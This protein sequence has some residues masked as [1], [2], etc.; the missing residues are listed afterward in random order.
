V[1]KALQIAVANVTIGSIQENTTIDVE[2]IATVSSEQAESVA[3]SVTD[4]TINS[5]LASAGMTVGVIAVV[6]TPGGTSGGPPCALGKYASF[7]GTECVP[8]PEGMYSTAINAVSFETCKKC[9]MGTYSAAVG[10]SSVNTCISC[11]SGTFSASRGATNI[12]TCNAG[13][14]FNSRCR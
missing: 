2:I 12:G 13:L 10:A 14:S 5:E 4:G 9:R 7:D 3:A 1:A 6:G 11:P 8:C